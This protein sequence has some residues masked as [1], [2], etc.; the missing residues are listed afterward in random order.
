M[1]GICMEMFCGKLGILFCGVLGNCF[2]S[3]L[4]PLRNLPKVKQWWS[5]F[6]A[7]FG[8]LAVIISCSRSR[9]TITPFAVALYI[10]STY[11]LTSSM[12][13]A[14]PAVTLARAAS[15]TF[16]GIRRT[17]YRDL[18]AHNCAVRQRDCSAGCIRRRRRMQPLQERSHRASFTL[19]GCYELSHEKQPLTRRGDATWWFHGKEQRHCHCFK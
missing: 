6:V 15:N 4:R 17:M 2:C 14:N 5:E 18:S 10:T 19:R 11:W 13:F 16:A 1:S 3:V 12:S 9:P 7:T 8:L